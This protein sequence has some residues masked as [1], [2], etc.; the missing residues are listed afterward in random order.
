VQCEKDGFKPK[1]VNVGAFNATKEQRLSA[2]AGAGAVGLLTMLIVNAASD[3]KTHD[4][5]YPSVRVEMEK[6]KPASRIAAENKA[7]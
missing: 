3:E 1:L 4:F 2:G 6:I 5:S 7:P